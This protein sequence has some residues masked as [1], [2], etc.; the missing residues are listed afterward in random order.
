METINANLGIDDT[1]KKI[2][3]NDL[4]RVIVIDYTSDVDFTELVAVLAEHIDE[5]KVIT[6]TIPSEVPADDK[7]KIVLETIQEIFIKYNSNIETIVVS[8][9]QAADDPPF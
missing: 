8:E 3:I 4:K 6:L 9:V 5:S 1:S 2:T 7:L